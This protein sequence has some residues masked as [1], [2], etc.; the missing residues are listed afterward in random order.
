VIQSEAE[1]IERMSSIA[2]RT[3]AQLG[4]VAAISTIAMLPLAWLAVKRLVP[5]R[6]IV[7]ARWGF[8][9]VAMAIGLFVLAQYAAFFVA[10]SER[11]LLGDLA[12]SGSAFAIVGIAIAAWSIRLDPDGVRVLGLRSSGTLRAVAAGLIVFFIAMPGIVGLMPIWRW[13]LQLAGHT[14]AMQDVAVRFAALSPGEQMIPIVLGVLVQPF[15]EELI[16]RSFLQPL[17][18]QNF[19]EV[20]G[21]A[22]TS[23]VFAAL[24]GP[25]VF[26]PIFALSCLLGAVML[27][28][29]N[30]YAVWAIHALNNG[31]MFALLVA[32]PDLVAGGAGT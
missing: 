23:F 19:R 15:L 12:I 24:H 20:A 5:D 16:F 29:Q 6:N 30:L 9:H 13:I 25:D 27:R 17:L 32:R 31:L 3:L 28:T 21:V 4:A 14:P 2:P 8:S 18:V 26:L 11:S 22:L 7:F 10:P 1:I